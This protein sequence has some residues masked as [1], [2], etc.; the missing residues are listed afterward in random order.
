MRNYGIEDNWLIEDLPQWDW[1]NRKKYSN[2]MAIVTRD[3]K[4]NEHRSYLP[5]SK[6]EDEY[7]NLC[8][9]NEGDILVVGCYNRRKSR[10]ETRMYYA[11]FGKSKDTITMEEY[12]TYR[13]AKK[14]LLEKEGTVENM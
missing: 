7:F 13:K 5:F 10:G 2:W 12:T 3:E 8:T 11:V 1:S 14:G 4:G 6:N 9:V